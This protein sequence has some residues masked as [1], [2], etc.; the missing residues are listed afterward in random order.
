MSVQDGRSDEFDEELLRFDEELLR[1][2]VP[3]GFASRA[4][5]EAAAYAKRLEDEFSIRSEIKLD[6]R[7]SND[8]VWEQ[9]VVDAKLMDVE[10]HVKSHEFEHFEGFPKAFFCQGI[11]GATF[12]GPFDLIEG[13]QH[14]R[15]QRESGGGTQLV[16]YPYDW[17]TNRWQV[18]EMSRSVSYSE[19]WLAT[20]DYEDAED[21]VWPWNT[22]DD[23]LARPDDDF[24][25]ID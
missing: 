7:H 15:S 4:K 3:T 12:K 1:M 25:D 14:L 21:I 9:W 13:L 10:V 11:E 20:Y 24:I 5:M 6:P 16:L 18:L 8:T 23:D 17:D 19:L 2:Y 22:G